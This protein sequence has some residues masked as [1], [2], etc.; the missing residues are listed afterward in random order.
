[1]EHSIRYSKLKNKFQFI[2]N[3]KLKPHNAKK[4]ISEARAYCSLIGILIFILGCVYILSV[5]IISRLL[6]PTS[7][8]TTAISKHSCVGAGIAIIGALI[9]VSSLLITGMIEFVL[10]NSKA[11]TVLGDTHNKYVPIIQQNEQSFD[12]SKNDDD[13]NSSPEA[14]STPT[15]IMQDQLLSHDTIEHPTVSSIGNEQQ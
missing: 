13:K 6:L 8:L 10:C 9:F 12:S 2:T 1:M 7:T 11:D 3:Q 4:Y 14:H 5:V 15:G